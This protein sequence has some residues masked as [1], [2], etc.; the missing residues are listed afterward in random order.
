MNNYYTG[1]LTISIYKSNYIIIIKPFFVYF[2]VK[3]KLITIIINTLQNRH[4]KVKLLE[5]IHI[6]YFQITLLETVSIILKFI[7]SN[8]IILNF[9]FVC[10]Q[11]N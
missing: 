11:I 3:K 7:I 9:F 8:T 4:N 5:V 1:I 6:I 10:V 2:C